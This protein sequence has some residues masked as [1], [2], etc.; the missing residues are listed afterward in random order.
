MGHGSWKMTY[1]HP[2]SPERN[3]WS[4]YFADRGNARLS[5]GF[6]WPKCGSTADRICVDSYS[7]DIG[8]VERLWRSDA[9]HAWPLTDHTVTTLTSAALSTSSN[10]T[11][12][13]FAPSVTSP[14]PPVTPFRAP[15]VSRSV[16][17]GSRD[18]RNVDDIDDV[19]SLIDDVTSTP[20]LTDESP[21]N[22]SPLT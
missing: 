5:V 20:G 7:C 15:D 22:C 10:L 17:I 1:F 9:L 14:R 19:T 3:C 6:F 13:H 18:T 2:C 11:S 8:V 16:W 12:T 4:V 21:T